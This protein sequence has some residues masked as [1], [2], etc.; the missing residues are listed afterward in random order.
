MHVQ[1]HICRG[2]RIEMAVQC[3]DIFIVYGSARMTVI[4]CDLQAVY[5]L[6]VFVD[7]ALSVTM[8]R[9]Q[10]MIERHRYVMPLLEF[11]VV[12]CVRQ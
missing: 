4:V 10:C 11:L 5:V 7:M 12:S 1:I 2:S 8:T 3:V 6:Y 9:G